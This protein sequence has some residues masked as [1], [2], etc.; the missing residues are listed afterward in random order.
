MAGLLHRLSQDYADGLLDRETYRTQR[1]ELIERI[2]NAEDDITRPMSPANG[3]TASRD[4]ALRG[5]DPGSMDL[6]I[7]FKSGLLRWGSDAKF[8]LAFAAAITAMLIMG[9]LYVLSGD[10]QSDATEEEGLSESHRPPAMEELYATYDG[11]DSHRIVA[12]LKREDRTLG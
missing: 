7:P 9:L 8:W 12:A 2:L 1:A 3:Q 10:N 5:R 4:L 11:H 6:F